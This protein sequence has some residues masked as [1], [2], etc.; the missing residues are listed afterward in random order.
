MKSTLYP[1]ALAGSPRRL[2]DRSHTNGSSHLAS[3]WVW[4]VEEIQGRR[5]MRCRFLF[6]PPQLNPCESLTWK[7]QF[8][9][10]QPASGSPWP[11][12]PLTPPGMCTG[13]APQAPHSPLGFPTPCPDLLNRLFIKLFSDYPIWGCHLFLA[14]TPTDPM[15]NI[16]YTSQSLCAAKWGSWM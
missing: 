13:T 16:L 6:H 1:T 7:S 3:C 2:M 9:S 10:H 15:S 5:P 8:F 14:G 11:L 12:A 4:S